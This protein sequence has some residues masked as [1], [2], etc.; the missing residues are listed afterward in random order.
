MSARFGMTQEGKPSEHCLDNTGPRRFFVVEQDN[1]G[2]HQQVSV[3]SYLAQFLNL[4]LVV[5]S[6]SRSTHG[7]FFV[8]GL[9]EADLHQFMN[10]ACRLGACH[11]TRTKSQFVRLP[12]GIRDHGRPSAFFSLTQR[13]FACPRGFL[14]R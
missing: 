2:P 11:S 9:P 14:S 10:L 8:E 6:G 13:L 12:G 1:G 7:W 4:V 5:Y 3:L